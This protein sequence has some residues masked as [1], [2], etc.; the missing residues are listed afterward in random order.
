MPMGSNEGS[1][2]GKS[3]KNLKDIKEVTGKGE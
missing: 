3:C 2:E 1:R